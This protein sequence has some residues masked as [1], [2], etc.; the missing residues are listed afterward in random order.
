MIRHYAEP[1]GRVIFDQRHNADVSARS[2]RLVIRVRLMT[3]AAVA[4][5][6]CDTPLTRG[7]P[8][9]NEGMPHGD[10]QSG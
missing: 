8:L 7:V 5:L 10:H 2:G 9:D 3:F 4:R 6:I 1:E